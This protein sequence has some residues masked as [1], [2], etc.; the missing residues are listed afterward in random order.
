VRSLKRISWKS[1]PTIVVDFSRGSIKMAAA[2]TAGEAV[3][4]KGM[5]YIPLPHDEKEPGVAELARLI[6]AEVKAHGW[7][8]LDCACLL[9]R[10]ATSTQSFLFPP[11][12]DADLRK[13]IAL[14]L[15]ETLHF[16]LDEASFD[17]RRI[18][19][20]TDGRVLTLVAAARNDAIEH[21]LSVL[22]AAGL[23]PVAIGSVAES[24]ANLAYYASPCEE[25]E[26]FVQV[27]L[28]SSSTIL[29]LF[30][31]QLL[32]F[33]R[34]IDTAGESFTRAL[35]RPILSSTGEALRLTREQ[36]EEVKCAAGYPRENRDV[37]LPH[38]V[39]SAEIL[40]LMEPVAQRLTTEIRRSI[41][42]LRGLMEGNDVDR[43][44]LSGPGAR[45]Q[46]LD[47]LLE[48]SL[49]T[50]VMTIDPVARAMDHLRL[51]ILD[52]PAPQPDGFAA[53]LGYS[54]G[55][56]RPVNL[57]PREEALKQMLERISRVRVAAV[58]LAMAAALCLAL[59]GIPIDRTYKATDEQMSWTAD[60]LDR[61]LRKAEKLAEVRALAESSVVGVANA[62]GPVPDWVGI[63]KE[64]SAIIPEDTQLTSL[65]SEWEKGVAV[66][67]IS[68]EVH[69][70]TAPF[71][72]VATQLTALLA[73][74]PFFSAVRVLD[75]SVIGGGR[76]GR[77]EASLEVVAGLPEPWR[78]GP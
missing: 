28:G 36:A 25:D 27:D 31:G 10:S 19:Q 37:E 47:A 44:V 29:N 34:E 32:R 42:Y 39:R 74:S 45:L 1:R 23:K 57:L 40:P 11:M 5:T 12:P 13:A 8:G 54:L 75:A 64:L 72:D 16:S 21:S 62:R 56:N 24:L 30:D 9:S 73:G 3:R 15:G 38:G 59:A 14:K 17:Y 22:R 26:A 50:P 53:I 60:H 68:A 69:E 33:S 76:G 55:N 43:I 41:D 7:Q 46:G 66:I 2:E 78:T 67:Y 77:F 20:Y 4:F 58:P 70:G 51:S 6:G 52:D 18:R 49:G 71:E 63:M 35:M 48:R 65:S 61:S